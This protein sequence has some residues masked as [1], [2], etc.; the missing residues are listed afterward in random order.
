MKLKVSIKLT[1]QKNCGNDY[2]K[3]NTRGFD[4]HLTYVVAIS[5]SAVLIFVLFLR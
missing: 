3:Y 2:H 5:V 1:E 4:Q